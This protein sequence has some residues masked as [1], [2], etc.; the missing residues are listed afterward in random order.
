MAD[1]CITDL[2]GRFYL[3]HRSITDQE[4]W[5]YNW[6]KEEKL[7]FFAFFERMHESGKNI[8]F[9]SPRVNTAALVGCCKKYLLSLMNRLFGLSYST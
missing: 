9:N 6:L 5:L 4:R 3:L 8:Y 1:R 7:N 2:N